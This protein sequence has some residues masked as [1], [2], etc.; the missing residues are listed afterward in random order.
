[1]AAA[2]AGLVDAKQPS[3]DSHFF[4]DLGA[5]SM[6]MAQF[7]ARVRK[8]ADLPPVSMKA[9]YQ[10]PTIRSLA[11]ALTV[12]ELTPAESSL[13]VV[14]N[15]VL[16]VEHV[17]VDSHFFDDL[18]ADSM[19]MAQFCARVRKRPDLPAVTMKDVYQ[20]P[21]IRSLAAAAAKPPSPPPVTPQPAAGAVTRRA[22]SR[23]YVVCGALQLLV[24][25]L[26]TYLAAVVVVK[27]Y[28]WIFSGSGTAQI[29]L[30]SVVVAGGLFFGQSLLPILAKWVLIG[31]WKPQEIQIWSLAYLRFWFVRTLI[32]ANPLVRL[33][34]GSPLYSLYLRALG[35]RVGKGVAIFSQTVPVCTDLLT[36]GNGTVIRK[37]SNLSCFRARDGVI[38][39]GPVTLGDDVLVGEVTVLDIDTSMGDGAQLGHSS[40][41]H[42]GQSVPAGERWH[43]SPA[44]RCDVNYQT[45]EP[46]RCGNLRRA[47]YAGMQLLTVL[48]VYL[49]I[50]TAAVGILLAW[51]PRLNAA[52]GIG[53]LSWSS[54]HLY[55][56]ALVASFVLVFGTMV[57]GLA[58]VV[59]VPR[60]LNLA[61]RP[62]RVYPLYG[63]HYSI[64][65]TIA[66]TTNSKFYTYLFGD[67]SYIV[68]YLQAIG[69]HLAPVVQT[70]SNFGSMVKHD[71]PYLVTVGSGTMVADGLSVINADFSSTSFRVSQVRIGARNFLGNHIVYPPQGRTGD[72]CL[73]ATK[74]LVPL[75]GELRE[76][77]GLLGSPSFEI[78]RSVERDRSF[79]ELH[80]TD[81][82][83]RRLARK[84]RYNLSS[85]G[86]ALLLRWAYLFG[87]ITL[88]LMTKTYHEEHG[89]IAVFL[90]VLA[91]LVFSLAFF[92]FFERLVARFR[93]LTPQFCS[94]YDPYFWWHERYWKFV[95]PAALDHRMVGTPFKNIVSRAQGA[96]LG[97]RVF[98]D[99]CSMPEKTLVAVGDECTLNAESVVQ[100][101]SQ[102]DG[103]FKSDRSTIGARCTIGVRALVH[104]GVTVG[105]GAVIAPDS[106]VMKGEEVPEGAHW[107]GNPASEMP[108]APMT[109]KQPELPTDPTRRR[110][111]A[112]VGRKD[113]A[114]AGWSWPEPVPASEEA[115]ADDWSWPAQEEQGEGQVLVPSPRRIRRRRAER[116]PQDYV[117]GG[118]Q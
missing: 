105:E 5:D 31:R 114:S 108:E 39:V 111:T 83:Q 50:G 63:V 25:L 16:R 95:I 116:A 53:S 48:L 81:E 69:Y 2:L 80:G 90:D 37:D 13:V 41:L 66:R 60:L 6:V 8:Q 78:P 65:R 27:G 62:D 51:F 101:H 59:T 92:A 35:A 33:I 68:P 88:A 56:D 102:E 44:R 20:H 118:R 47:G 4:D 22:T 87:V 103:S 70:G 42:T 34:V 100:T 43:G 98:D 57:V 14:L 32:R 112:L 64:Q 24:F 12:A 18:G 29:Y 71:V 96:R 75:D 19:V 106:F 86:L 38:Q 82:L 85:M 58:F 94:V 45:V 77:V 72:N 30:R 49:P 7:C 61:L 107:G 99:G 10:Y 117:D 9:V 28:G 26:Y 11:R 15:D 104:Y 97:K 54:W 76:G 3:V 91:S 46:A 40:S 84:N 115:P 79:E 74:V 36:I 73:L 67:S 55:R 17:S 23:Q 110:A 89:V 109:R 113:T 21:T 52:L 93:P 1:M